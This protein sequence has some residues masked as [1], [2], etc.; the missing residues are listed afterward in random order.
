MPLSPEEA[1]VLAVL[2]EKETTVPDSYPLTLN[3]LRLGC[4]QTSNRFPI[5]AYEDRTVEN[6]LMSLKSIGLARFVH[7]SH[8]GRTIRYRHVADERWHLGRNELAV[9]SVL[10]LRGPQTAG[11][12]KARAG[13]QLHP[14]GLT[15]DEA[16]D[17]LAARSP[18]AFA[19]QL[20]RRPGERER[21]WAHLLCGEADE[22]VADP[23]GPIT[24]AAAPAP[25][26]VAELEAE[27]A[28]LRSRLDRLETLLGVELE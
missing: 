11:E 2:I 6:A 20:E 16:L 17:T 7:P 25:D 21:R 10:A 18:E 23:T 12:V 14:D 15:V 4:N 13:R 9:L 27:V 24:I 22:T 28:A 3:A 26:R 8:G 1:R 19:V 5:V